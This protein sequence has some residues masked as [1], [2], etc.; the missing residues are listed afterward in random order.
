MKQRF[1]MR[2]LPAYLFL[3]T[4]TSMVTVPLLSC[5]AV[6][7]EMATPFYDASKYDP[8]PIP[9]NLPTFVVI[10][11]RSSNLIFINMRRDI[12]PEKYFANALTQSITQSS[13]KVADTDSKI[14]FIIKEF[15]VELSKIQQTRSSGKITSNISVDVVIYSNETTSII[16]SYKS[17]Y[18]T[19]IENIQFGADT[20]DVKY[21]LN[22]NTYNVLKKIFA[23]EAFV[24]AINRIL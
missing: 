3:F 12:V 24:A 11:Q 2:A 13:A 16:G 14:K 21:V 7:E 23:D 10:D 17:S 9:K 6:A 20:S 18:Y 19:D 4:L 5:P 1:L 22:R 8:L 15:V